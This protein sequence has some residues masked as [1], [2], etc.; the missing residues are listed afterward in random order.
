M[1][2]A[3]VV[4]ELAI[5][6]R[7]GTVHLLVVV[8]AL[9]TLGLVVLAEWL[10][11]QAT[12]LNPP[13]IGSATPQSQTGLANAVAADVGVAL[14]F[15]FTVWMLVLCIVVASSIG[16]QIVA[17]ERERGLLEML[18]S[19]GAR[20][21]TIVAAKA[22]AVLAQTGMVLLGGLPLLAFVFVFGD[23][24]PR[25]L[26]GSVVLVVAWTLA[27][28]AV[29]ICCSA[30]SHTSSSGV[31]AAFVG[32][33]VV[34]LTIV[35]GPA[36]AG[37]FG[38]KV[39]PLAYALNPIVAVLALQPELGQRLVNLLPTNAWLPPPALAAVS[40]RHALAAFVAACL[41]LATPLLAAASLRLRH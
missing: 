5:S 1:I 32:S 7:R 13:T 2:V 38:A 20:P 21:A 36:V 4:R 23:V 18:L 29:G 28:G 11:R 22:L 6:L 41:V 31:I 33:V 40:A 34:M 19:T 16:G 39:P 24:V 14:L 26:F 8:H 17:R 30:W 25:I 35:I 12:P 37:Q 10:V 3:L 27:V 9:L 15:G